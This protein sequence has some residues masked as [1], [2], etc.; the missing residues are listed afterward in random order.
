MELRVKR[1]YDPPATDDGFR[2][3]IDRLWP[4]GLSKEHA[5]LDLWDKDVAPSRELRTAFHHEGMSWEDFEKA[6]RAEVAADGPAVAALRDQLSGHPVVTLLYA[7]H[8]EA[9][10][11][12]ILLREA[13]EAAPAPGA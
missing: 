13:L 5:A 1:V 6:Y 12:A 2:V 4:R 8:D 10:N 7:T 9:H 3:L 11:H